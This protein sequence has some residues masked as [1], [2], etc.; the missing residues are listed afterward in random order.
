MRVGS[1]IQFHRA[2]KVDNVIL[3]KSWEVFYS[4]LFTVYAIERV[5]HGLHSTLIAGVVFRRVL[6]SG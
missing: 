4:I 1:F 2:N 6:R 3:C 5:H